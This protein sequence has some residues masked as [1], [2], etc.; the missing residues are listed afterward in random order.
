MTQ[1][2][3]R[4]AQGELRPHYRAF[5]STTFPSKVL[6]HK[7]PFKV[8]SALNKYPRISFSGNRYRRIY[9]GYIL[10]IDTSN[11]HVFVITNFVFYSRIRIIPLFILRRKIGG[12]GKRPL[13]FIRVHCVLVKTGTK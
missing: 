11:S 10:L 4:L 13:G 7:E 8:L 12:R 6:F 1:V 5:S 3:S 2:Q 9:M